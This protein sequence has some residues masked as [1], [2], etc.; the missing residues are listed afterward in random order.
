MNVNKLFVIIVFLLVILLVLHLYM[1]QTLKK[2]ANDV[3][4]QINQVAGNIP[5]W[6]TG[7]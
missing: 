6:L 7:L 1:I 5:S 2:G 3:Q 4:M